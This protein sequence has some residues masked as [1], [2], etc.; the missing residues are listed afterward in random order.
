MDGGRWPFALPG[1]QESGGGG[2]NEAKTVNLLPAWY[3]RELLQ[4]KR[5][6]TYLGAMLVLGAALVVTAQVSKAH[7]A[8]V[9]AEHATL[10]GRASVVKDV[11]PE[12]EEIR[13]ELER[14]GER[15]RA[16]RELGPT[17]PVSKLAQQIFNNMSEGMSLS[18]LSVEVRNEAVKG[19]GN[20]GDKQNPPRYHDV[21]HLVVVG[22]APVDAPVNA[23]FA[24]L[25]DNV[26]F[27]DVSMTYL[28]R[29]IL[30]DYEVRRFE[31]QMTVDLDRL[32]IE[33]P[34]SAE[35]PPA[36]GDETKAAAPAKEADHG[37]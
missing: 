21:A 3:R 20:V 18:R 5:L 13:G 7:L 8:K 11:T 4:R 35:E 12:I 31:L 32:S 1:G 14:L 34:E 37:S 22:V 17:V 23:M 27:S 33:T 28:R 24:R 36:G 26:L 10:A 19:T 25:S 30:K 9:R 2:M 15:Q 16:C 6:R 29:E